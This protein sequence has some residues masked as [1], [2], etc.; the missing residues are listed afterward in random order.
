M[1]K[2]KVNH[3]LALSNVESSS[4][5]AYRCIFITLKTML[6]NEITRADDI[7]EKAINFWY[8]HNV[9][10]P[11]LLSPPPATRIPSETLHQRLGLSSASESDSGSTSTPNS[12]MYSPTSYL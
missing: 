6:M 10:E 1:T 2:L 9:P 7:N 8:E 5:Q 12:P 11:P 3:A 4:A